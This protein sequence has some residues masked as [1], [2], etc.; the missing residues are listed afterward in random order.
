M[1]NSVSFSVPLARK[2]DEEHLGLIKEN[3]RR[4]LAMKTK[5]AAQKE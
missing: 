3:E 4:E 2:Q 5:R 1:S